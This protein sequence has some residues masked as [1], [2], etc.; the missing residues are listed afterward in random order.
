ME[1]RSNCCVRNQIS[2]SKFL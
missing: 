1:C 2:I